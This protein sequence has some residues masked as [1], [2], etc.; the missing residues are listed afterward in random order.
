[1]LLKWMNITEYVQ[2]LQFLFTTLSAPPDGKTLVSLPTG[3]GY[4][5][6]S[7][8]SNSSDHREFVQV[9]C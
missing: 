6:P 4:T 5:V 7:S 8:V 1:M 9:C 2:L 3:T